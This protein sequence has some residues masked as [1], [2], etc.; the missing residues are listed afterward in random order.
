MHIK[1]DQHCSK[2]GKKVQ[3]KHFESLQAKQDKHILLLHH[4]FKIL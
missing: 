4:L 1:F 2:N 3:R